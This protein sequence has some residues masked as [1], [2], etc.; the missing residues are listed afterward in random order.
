V[1]NSCS[2]G[3]L[4]ASWNPEALL[5]NVQRAMSVEISIA[6]PTYT[7]GT[8][9]DMDIHDL[10][11]MNALEWFTVRV[12]ICDLE[13]SLLHTACTSR[14]VTATRS[15]TLE[16]AELLARNSTARAMLLCLIGVAVCFRLCQIILLLRT[17]ILHVYRLARLWVHLHEVVKHRLI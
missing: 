13:C 17:N 5:S 2:G 1:P 12:V 14:I 3:T 8:Y 9:V 11:V 15:G 6:E 10:Y 4:S 16:I 7:S